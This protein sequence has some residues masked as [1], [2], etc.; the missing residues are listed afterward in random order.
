[1]SSEAAPPIVVERSTISVETS[2][3]ARRQQGGVRREAFPGCLNNSVTGST[4]TGYKTPAFVNLEFHP[5]VA[6]EFPRKDFDLGL[7]AAGEREMPLPVVS[8]AHRI[9]RSLTGYGFADQD[10]AALIEL[11][12]RPDGRRPESEHA[13]ISHGLDSADTDGPGKVP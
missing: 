10:F 6:A 8:L 7:A 11:E 4:F 12:A 1:M 2:Q 9:V 3:Q 13:D 5:T